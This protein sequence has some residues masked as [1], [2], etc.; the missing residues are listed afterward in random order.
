[1][2]SILTWSVN[3]SGI[4]CLRVLQAPFH[5]IGDYFPHDMSSLHH[6]LGWVERGDVLVSFCRDIPLEQTIPML[7]SAVNCYELRTVTQSIQMRQR[8]G[9]R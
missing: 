3:F 9:E 6:V 5:V 4:A 7:T 1:M 8:R 2:T